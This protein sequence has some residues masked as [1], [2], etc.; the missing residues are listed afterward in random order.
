MATPDQLQSLVSES[1]NGCNSYIR[2]PLARKLIYTDGIK[3]VADLCG[4]Y[5]LL[6]IIGTEAAPALMKQYQDGYANVGLIEVR[7]NDEGA[8]IALTLD[9]DAPDAW[10]RHIEYTDFP[11]GHWVFKLG[12]DTVLV[13][14]E[15]VCVMCLLSE[16]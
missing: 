1:R 6:D 14:G 5:W 16:D 3:E 12:M 15:T 7:V 13:P 11:H 4:A 2:H 8:V 10:S 9:D